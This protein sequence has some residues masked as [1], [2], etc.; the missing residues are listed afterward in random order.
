MTSDGGLGI[1]P[2]SE[3]WDHVDS[4][5]GLHNRE[6]NELWIRLWTTRQITSVKLEKIREQFGASIAL[7]FSFVLS[8][9]TALIFPS[10][11]GIIFY[12]LD[13]SCSLLYSSLLLLWS[14]TFIEWWTIQERILSVQWGTRGSANVEKMRTTYTCDP[15]TQ[16]VESKININLNK[17]KIIQHIFE[18][19]HC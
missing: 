15:S 16:G 19:A 17:P 5:L 3:E 12:L 2:G 9:A 10:I 13:Q 6:F 18:L 1:I 11:V 7:Y 14:I 8:Y 4:V